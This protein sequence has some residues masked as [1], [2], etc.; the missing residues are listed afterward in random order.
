MKFDFKKKM[1]SVDDDLI[2]ELI[3]KAEEAMV[4]P[5]KKSKV[6]EVEPEGEEDSESSEVESGEEE[7][8]LDPEDLKKLLEIYNTM[9]D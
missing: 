2:S 8:S 3:S 6:E 4:H 9:K 7:D 1:K 5:L